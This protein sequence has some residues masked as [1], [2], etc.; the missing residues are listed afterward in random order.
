M[1]NLIAKDSRLNEEHVQV[2][3]N[4]YSFPGATTEIKSPRGTAAIDQ[5][6]K[7]LIGLDYFKNLRKLLEAAKKLSSFLALSGILWKEKIVCSRKLL[8]DAHVAAVCLPLNCDNTATSFTTASQ[9]NTAI[10]QWN[11]T[12]CTHLQVLKKKLTA[13]DVPCSLCGLIFLLID[14][15]SLLTHSFVSD[16]CPARWPVLSRKHSWKPNEIFTD[17][18][19]AR[20]WRRRWYQKS[21][22]TIQTRVSETKP[23]LLLELFFYNARVF[24]RK[25]S[26]SII[27]WQQ[28]IIP[29]AHFKKQLKMASFCLQNLAFECLF[30]VVFLPCSKLRQCYQKKRQ[31]LTLP[32]WL[33]MSPWHKAKIYQ[34]LF[35][36]NGGRF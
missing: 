3:W 8:T 35:E 29:C 6:F 14:S 4:K 27:I 22:T 20:D 33:S 2:T 21:D 23:V 32:R 16:V 25:T 34:K 30:P 9:N 31:R 18:V 15:C 26:K 13:W 12:N 7:L 24:Y 17:K 11:Q 1:P 10:E 5:V 36:Q 19:Y 28:L